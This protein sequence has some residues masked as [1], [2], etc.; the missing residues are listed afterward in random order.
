MTTRRLFAVLLVFATLLAACAPAAPRQEPVPPA[1]TEQT[2]ISETETPVTGGPT[3]EGAVPT[4]EP[5]LPEETRVPGAQ[6][7]P[8]PENYIWREIPGW[9]EQPTDITSPGDGSGRVF[10]LERAGRIRIIQNGELLTT[11]FL[12]IVNIVG[13]NASERGLLGLAFHPN[14]PENGFFYV[15]YTDRD[16]NTRIARF[17]V[18]TSD[19]NLA[20][21]SSRLELIRI[22][23][24]YGNHNGGSLAFGPDGYLYAGLGDGGSAGDPLDA[25]QSLNTLLGKLLRFDVDGGQPYAIPP[26]NPFAAGGGEAEI[27]AYGLRN[28]WKIAFDRATGDLYIADVGQNQWEEVNFTPAGTPGGLNYGWRFM[29]GSHDYSGGLYD[30]SALILPVAEYTR[31]G[32]C[33]VTGG[34]VYRGQA[35]PEWQGVYLYGDFC[36]G[37]IW[38][39]LRTEDGF[40]NSLLFRTNFRI[41]T[42]GLDD[43]GEIYLG[44]YGGTIY[45]LTER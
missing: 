44:D 45:Q 11:P 1:P 18:S 32:G 22:E 27:W 34:H 28:P 23:Q 7:L 33:S 30:R 5:A 19:P 14:Y 4:L 31:D 15:N 21:P 12:D 2:A 3:V 37:N 20:D 42:F 10:A 25:G 38:G 41:S 26:D 39:L 9:L 13:S 43:D 6:S 17:S 16:G 24:P 36:S 29:E 8:N 40:I 35:L